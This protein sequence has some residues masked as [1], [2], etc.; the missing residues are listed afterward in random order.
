MAV[1]LVA[2]GAFLWS[3]SHARAGFGG[4]TTYALPA[5]E[6]VMIKA[7]FNGDGKT[8]LAL[9]GNDLLIYLGNG[10]GT[11]TAEAPI[12]L[13][14][15]FTDGGAGG[16]ILAGDFNGDGKLDLVI[17]GWQTNNAP[18]NGGVWL[19]T[20]NGNGTF[21][22]ATLLESTSEGSPAIASGDFNGDG[23]LDLAYE[24]TYNN[25]SVI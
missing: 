3:G 24:F 18:S 5:S 6:T 22:A 21:N 11:F 1:L 17:S 8:D 2:G 19:M 9:L 25:L 14:A 10:D 15:N 12:P 4:A 23:K 16:Q 7:D 13:P 20:G